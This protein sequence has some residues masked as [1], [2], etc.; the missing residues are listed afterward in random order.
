MVY[1]NRTKPPSL[2]L[3]MVSSGISQLSINGHIL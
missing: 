3:V 2:G 1:F